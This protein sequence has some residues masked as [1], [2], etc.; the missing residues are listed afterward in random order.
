M[1]EKVR[2]EIDA[3]DLLM[4]D[5]REMESL[6]RTFEHLHRN[7]EQTRDVIASACAELKIHDTLETAIFYAAVGEAADDDSIDRLVADAEDEHDAILELI[8]KLEKT[9]ADD[10]HR[11]AQ[12]KALAAQ[13]KRHVL[14][15]E[16]ERFPLVKKMQRLDLEAVT[17]AMKKR[18]TQ[19]L[20][21]M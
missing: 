14:T 21:E 18:K 17:A 15:D 4:Q 3:F 5:H 2:Q 20:T 19:L 12:F 11:N 9:P 16:T 1:T 6:L 8:E 10:L 13:V 7:G